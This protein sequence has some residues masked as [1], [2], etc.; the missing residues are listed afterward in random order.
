MKLMGRHESHIEPSMIP[1]TPGVKEPVK[2]RK[3]QSWNKMTTTIGPEG[4]VTLRV[5]QDQTKVKGR[6]L[7]KTPTLRTST[8]LTNNQDSSSTPSQG[9][10]T[11]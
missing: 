8:P 11:H 10:P 4:N 2:V 7:W 3:K 6:R 5:R 1:S 9:T